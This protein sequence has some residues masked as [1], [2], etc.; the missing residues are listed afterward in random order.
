MYLT[1]LACKGCGLG[2]D[3]GVH[4]VLGYCWRCYDLRVSDERRSIHLY[5]PVKRRRGIERNEDG[6]DVTDLWSPVLAT[7]DRVRPMWT[8]DQRS[9]R[10]SRESLASKAS[11]TNVDGAR[12]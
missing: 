7:F 3:R 2:L 12:S 9:R 6:E 1:V 8:R 4:S 5:L 10:E 11:R